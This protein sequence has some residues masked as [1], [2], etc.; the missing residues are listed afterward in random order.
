MK[1][2]SRTMYITDKEYRAN[3]KKLRKQLPKGATRRLSEEFNAV[4]MTIIN[5]L[6]GRTRRFDIIDRAIEMAK[7]GQQTAQQLKEFVNG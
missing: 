6:N 4:P 2:K 5:A 1:E 7:E 3:L